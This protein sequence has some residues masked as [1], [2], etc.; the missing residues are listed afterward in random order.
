[1]VHQV[2]PTH[3]PTHARAHDRYTPESFYA[4]FQSIDL[5][6]NMHDFLRKHWKKVHGNSAVH[7]R[8]LDAK[9][10]LLAQTQQVSRSGSQL[11]KQAGQ[12][13]SYRIHIWAKLHIVSG[14]G[15]PKI[16]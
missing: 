9:L 12:A 13:G 14:T 15:R 10:R 16:G 8:S 2:P 1:M 3:A 7:L 4:V 5:R 11:G 6:R